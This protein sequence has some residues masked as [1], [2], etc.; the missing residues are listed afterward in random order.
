MEAEGRDL[1]HLD[2]KLGVSSIHLCRE[3][4]EKAENILKKYNI[5]NPSTNDSLDFKCLKRNLDRKL[6]LAVKQKFE[7][8]KTEDYVSPWILPQLLNK[9][10]ESLKEVVF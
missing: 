7:D 5:D 4:N 10:G 9:E 8:S 3:W 1:S 2:Q 6:V